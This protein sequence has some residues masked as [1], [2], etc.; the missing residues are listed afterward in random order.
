MTDAPEQ[1]ALR[2]ELGAAVTSGPLMTHPDYTRYVRED[3]AFTADD[4]RRAWEMGRDAA[5]A[6]IADFLAVPSESERADIFDECC[7]LLAAYIR[8]LTPPALMKGARD[9]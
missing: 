4:L 7:H 8:A 6:E 3:A 5:L 1:I 2:W 9:E